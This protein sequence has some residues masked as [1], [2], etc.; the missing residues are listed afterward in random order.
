ML[1]LRVTIEGVKQTVIAAV[2]ERL[3]QDQRE[4]SAIVDKAVTDADLGRMIEGATEEALRAEIKR[5]CENA[6][7][8]LFRDNDVAACVRLAAKRSIGAVVL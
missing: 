8:E 4:L 2:S 3:A 6:V 1:Q 5:A 7:R